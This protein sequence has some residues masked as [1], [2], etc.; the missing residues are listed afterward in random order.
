MSTTEP[1]TRVYDV[2][3]ISCAHC[4]EAIEREV[5]AVPDVAGVEVD[6][7]AKRVV[8]AGGDDTAIRAAIDDAGY[9]VAS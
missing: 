3:G 5:G 6:V 8:V 2:P 7:D 9:D 1:T 4:K